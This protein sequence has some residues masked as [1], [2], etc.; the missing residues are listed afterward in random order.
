MQT[1][2]VNPTLDY[3]ISYVCLLLVNLDGKSIKSN[4]HSINKPSI[5]RTGLANQHIATATTE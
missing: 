2:V 3:V 5:D 1:V 4:G